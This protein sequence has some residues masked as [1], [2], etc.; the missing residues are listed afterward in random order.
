MSSGIYPEDAVIL[1]PLSGYTD[2]PFRMS[3]RRHGCR[4][5]FTEMIDAGSLVFG[6]EKTLRFL[7][8][9]ENED[10]LGIQLVGSDVATLSKATEIVNRYEFSVI[11][12][13]LGCPAPKV[14]K[15]GEGAA[16][17]RRP[18]EAL[19]AFESIKLK[20]RFPVTAKTR[21]LDETDPAPT[22]KFCKRLEAAGA[23]VITL[24]GR[25]AKNFYSGRVFTEII[26]AVRENLRIPLVANGGI[27]GITS[28]NQ[29]RS[30]SGSSRV[31]LAR[32][33]MGHPWLFAELADPLS[34][35][36]PTVSEL[37]DEL[38][39]H[40]ND[41][42]EFYGEELAL[43]MCRKVIL[44]YT[45]GR[46]YSGQLRAS[47]S[48]LKSIADFAVFMAEVR[49]GPSERYW[50]WLENNVAADRRIRP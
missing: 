23:E 25:L 9:N 36:P 20:S 16:L 26:S 30:E 35:Q 7:T 31:M 42:I 50:K 15:K 32:G 41:M 27:T 43:R 3:A 28:Y 37:A 39:Q 10:W 8:R 38:E 4:F 6:N 46:G 47:V 18:D 45:S 17:A 33:V 44:D 19:K 29:I 13:N 48:F 2:M 14:A 22:I 21:I 34:Y 24:H 5:A 1:A 12:F 49:N 40:I 11:D